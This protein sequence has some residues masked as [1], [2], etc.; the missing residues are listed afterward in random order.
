MV[1][2]V[3]GGVFFWC[4]FGVFLSCVSLWVSGNFQRFLS[5][6]FLGVGLNKFNM[7]V[8]VMC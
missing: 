4:K 2:G 6:V 1:L 5:V 8:T 3:C 7:G